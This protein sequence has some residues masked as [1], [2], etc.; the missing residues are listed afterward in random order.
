MQIVALVPPSDWVEGRVQAWR[1][2]IRISY[3][4]CN[5]WMRLKFQ[6]H[7]AVSFWC[8]CPF[9]SFWFLFSAE[10]PI[11]FLLLLQWKD[12]AEWKLGCPT[13]KKVAMTNLG[14]VY[15]WIWLI[16]FAHA[17]TFC[18]YRRESQLHSTQAHKLNKPYG[19]L[20]FYQQ[21]PL[22]TSSQNFFPPLINFNVAVFESPNRLCSVPAQ[23]AENESRLLNLWSLLLWTQLWPN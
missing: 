19:N 20:C 2:F 3:S 9:D 16:R 5:C 17:V 23:S 11:S 12:E 22:N 21:L 1:Y 6:L 8:M 15:L 13:Q 14:H 4:G 10:S 7:L 18:E